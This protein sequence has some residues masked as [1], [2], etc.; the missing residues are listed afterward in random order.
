MG[1]VTH[2]IYEGSKN[3]SL[4]KI[5]E[6]GSHPLYFFDVINIAMYVHA[7]YTYAGLI[8]G[9]EGWWQQIVQV[10]RHGEH[11]Y[12]N[13]MTL[14]A[15]VKKNT[16]YLCESQV[17]FS[18]LLYDFTVNLQNDLRFIKL[19]S[20][21]Q[22]SLFSSRWLDIIVHLA[23]VCWSTKISKSDNITSCSVR[24][25]WRFQFLVFQSF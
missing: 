3:S 23:V 18:R 10:M 17:G 25:L 15:V 9:L 20:D 2:H 6:T 21:F 11:S 4:S 12:T 14:G 7:F 5:L 22:K 8:L 13:T 24:A 16:V 1:E 19:L